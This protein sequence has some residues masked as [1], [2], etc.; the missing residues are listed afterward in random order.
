MTL[1]CFNGKYYIQA[2]DPRTGSDIVMNDLLVCDLCGSNQFSEQQPMIL[3]K[4]SRFLDISECRKENCVMRP[5]T[6]QNSCSARNQKTVLVQ[7]TGRKSFDL[8]PFKYV[9]LKCQAMRRNHGITKTF[10]TVYSQTDYRIGLRETPRRFA[11][12]PIVVSRV[13]FL[14]ACGGLSFSKFSFGVSQLVFLERS[15]NGNN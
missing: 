5:S 10:S 12:S 7:Q 6:G 14:F 1:E 2:G 8:L 11:R 13:F 9:E 3:R 15:R 4:F